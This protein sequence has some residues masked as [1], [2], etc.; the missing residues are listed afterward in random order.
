MLGG[1]DVKAPEDSF[2]YRSHPSAYAGAKK[3]RAQGR[4]QARVVPIGEGIPCG[5]GCGEITN[6]VTHND[7]SRGRIAGTPYRFVS[8]HN[9]RLLRRAA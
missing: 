5:C 4:R 7:R 9:L 2:R 8:G 1:C 3:R 6:V